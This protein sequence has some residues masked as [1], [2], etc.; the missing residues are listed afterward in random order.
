[1]NASATRAGWLRATLVGAVCALAAQ[2]TALVPASSAS[3]RVD[4][5][6]INNGSAVQTTVGNSYQ[7]LPHVVGSGAV[8]RSTSASFTANHGRIGGLVVEGDDV[9][10][11]PSWTNQGDVDAHPTVGSAGCRPPLFPLVFGVSAFNNIPDAIAAV[12]SGGRVI[13]LNAD[14]LVEDIAVDRPVQLFGYDESLA[15][16]PGLP[17]RLGAILRPAT[18]TVDPDKAILS[19]QSA[20]VTVRALSIDGNRTDVGFPDDSEVEHAIFLEDNTATWNALR[21]DNVGISSARRTGVRIVAPGTTAHTIMNTDIELVGDVLDSGS[22]DGAGVL[23]GGASGSVTNGSV[24]F[25]TSGVVAYGDGPNSLPALIGSGAVPSVTVRDGLYA[26][27]GTGTAV[28]PTTSLGAVSYRA[29]ATG[30]V[31]NVSIVSSDFGVTVVDN[32][33][34]GT[35]SVVESAFTGPMRIGVDVRELYAPVGSGGQAL[36]QVF[37]NTFTG[38]IEQAGVAARYIGRDS[39]GT[40]EAGAVSVTDNDFA[41][42]AG[43]TLGTVGVFATAIDPAEGALSVANNVMEGFDPVSSVAGIEISSLDALAGGATPYPSDNISVDGNVIS[44]W[45]VGVRMPNPSA[46]V[47]APLGATI[48]T[49]DANLIQNNIFGVL[50]GAQAAA[51]IG[52]P[53]DRSVIENNTTGIDVRGATSV[54]TVEGVELRNNTLSGLRVINGGQ[55]S[56]QESL[57][58]TALEDSVGVRAGSGGGVLD[59]GGGTLGSTGN[60]V[61]DVRGLDNTWAVALESAGTYSARENTWQQDGVTYN[62]SVAIDDLIRDG[63]TDNPFAAGEGGTFGP[64]AFHPFNAGTLEANI[65]IDANAAR[66]TTPQYGTTVFRALSDAPEAVAPGGVATVLDGSYTAQSYN[67]DSEYVVLTVTLD[68]DAVYTA[69]NTG[70]AVVYPGAD[71]PGTEVADV[72]EAGSVTMLTITADDVLLAGLVLDG[73]SPALSGSVDVNGADINARNA[74]VLLGTAGDGPDNVTLQELAIRNVFH[75]GVATIPEPGS[76]FENLRV[77]GGTFDNIAGSTVDGAESVAIELA[78]V[79]D[80]EVRGNTISD[81]IAGIVLMAN[82]DE[83]AHAIEE[84]VISDAT[85]AAIRVLELEDQASVS[86]ADNTITGGGIGIEVAGLSLGANASVVDNSVTDAETALLAMGVDADSLLAA[87]GN[88]LRGTGTS[89]GILTLETAESGPGTGVELAGNELEDHA[90]ALHVSNAGTPG[91]ANTGVRLIASTIRNNATG[92]LIEDTTSEPVYALIG[93][94]DPVDRNRFED[95]TTGVRISGPTAT[96]DVRNNRRFPPTVDSAFSGGDVGILVEDGAAARLENN[97]FNG[98]AV[99]AI[100]IRGA[101]TEAL[102]ERNRMSGDVGNAI[103]ILIEDEAVTSMGPGPAASVSDP[104]FGAT[105][106]SIGL[107]ILRDFAGGGNFAIENLSIFDQNA[108]NNDFGTMDLGVIEDVVE[109]E[110]DNGFGFVFYDPPSDQ[111]LGVGEWSTL[112][113][114]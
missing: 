37:A 35:V 8:G 99:A 55:A 14:Y 22:A 60:N 20:N 32:E 42:L 93:P 36:V 74:V 46:A 90:I 17:G 70:G 21:V 69:Q 78:D 16:C 98:A 83:S 101:G 105:T 57:V 53:L 95:N 66:D 97:L 11:D 61:L 48:G 87:S 67:N 94:D 24:Q 25:A 51:T 3:Y 108:E 65:T 19:I 9:F 15:G 30:L 110:P 18:A 44:D 81:A 86:V 43:T 50:L 64:L 100:R 10:V 104:F 63:D 112:H 77:L 68:R 73:D 27:L 38:A 13:L 1:M 79:R 102:I 89:T 4:R 31:E 41:S 39:V 59:L 107:N 109:H 88:V 62:G 82:D 5:T 12:N 34:D 92:V 23:F 40:Q 75:R 96:A 71:G 85:L 111:F 54:A 45:G 29:N 76:L 58:E 91:A 113:D 47:T 7:V 2:A 80:S 114:N 103:G 72:L 49:A 28:G 26:A 84:N 52:N 33:I 106:D 56:L 6:S